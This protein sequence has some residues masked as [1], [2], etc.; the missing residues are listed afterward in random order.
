MVRT[1]AGGH[2]EPACVLSLRRRRLQT[3]MCVR[4]SRLCL[5]S[6][7]AITRMTL[8]ILEALNV[9]NTDFWYRSGL[10]A[11]RI[12]KKEDESQNERHVVV[13]I[14]A[15]F[16]LTACPNVFMNLHLMTVLKQESLRFLVASL[17]HSGL[18]Q[19]SVLIKET[20][21]FWNRLSYSEVSLDD[22]CLL[23]S[24]V[25][26]ICCWSKDKNL[27]QS[28]RTVSQSFWWKCSPQ[29]QDIYSFT[30]LGLCDSFENSRDAKMGD[31]I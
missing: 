20:H 3:L 30:R 12:K 18:E 16:A 15:V 27:L 24:R 6:E 29:K 1:V 2:R 22:F 7:S 11:W 5:T 17:R 21:S 28:Q 26:I 14:F 23:K 10:K 9:C 19:L 4:P 31:G 13:H 8:H 25:K